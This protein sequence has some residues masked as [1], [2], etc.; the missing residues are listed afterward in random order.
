MNEA[1]RGDSSGHPRG[2]IVADRFEMSDG[3]IA[4]KCRHERA[5][6]HDLA[7]EG[8]EDE[9]R[10]AGPGEHRLAEIVEP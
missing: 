8:R 3:Q 9:Q 5:E 10:P 7:A 1:G 6:R 4:L 2:K